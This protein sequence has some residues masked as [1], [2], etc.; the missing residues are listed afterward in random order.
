MCED[1][2]WTERYEVVIGKKK[3]KKKIQGPRWF[4]VGIR[5][6]P[7]RIITLYTSEKVDPIWAIRY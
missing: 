4:E 3:K 7:P 1:E 2:D 6:M 5:I